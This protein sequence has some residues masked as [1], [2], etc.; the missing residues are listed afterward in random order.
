MVRCTLVKALIIIYY[1]NF[2]CSLAIKYT[3]LYLKK[4]ISVWVPS[5]V[6]GTYGIYQGILK[7]VTLTTQRRL[8]SLPTPMVGLSHKTRGCWPC[9]RVPQRSGT[10]SMRDECNC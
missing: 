7:K 1:S 5:G 6:G 3:L 9:G 8:T 10:L 2:G 4:H